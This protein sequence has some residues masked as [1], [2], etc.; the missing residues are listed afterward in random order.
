MSANRHDIINT[1]SQVCGVTPLDLFGR[2]KKRRKTRARQ[3]AAYFLRQ[4]GLPLQQAGAALGDMHHT[5]VLHSVRLIDTKPEQFEPHLS[6]IKEAL[7]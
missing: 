2:D 7:Q 3:M 5:T 1:V 6:A 4:S